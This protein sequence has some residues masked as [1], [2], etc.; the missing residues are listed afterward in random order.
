MIVR[1]KGTLW[2]GQALHRMVKEL[3]YIIFN[4]SQMITSFI[5]ATDFDDAIRDRIP[6][7]ERKK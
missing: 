6:Q 7:Q 1:H 3:R 2:I 5:Q 4:E